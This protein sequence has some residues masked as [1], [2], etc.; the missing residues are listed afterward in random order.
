MFAELRE[1]SLLQV[2]RKRL[3]LGIN[4]SLVLCFVVHV[5]LYISQDALD[6][7]WT[8]C[9]VN[10]QNCLSCENYVECFARI[11]R[12][13]IPKIDQQMAKALAMVC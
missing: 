3:L 12:A 8:C 1:D 10:E 6:R 2:H 4:L 13:L 5:V 7:F 11:A 9:S